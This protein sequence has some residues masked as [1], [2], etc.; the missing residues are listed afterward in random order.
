MSW[1][2]SGFSRGVQIGGDSDTHKFDGRGIQTPIN[3]TAGAME[4]GSARGDSRRSETGDSDTHKFDG[5]SNGAADPLSATR[6]GLRP[7]VSRQPSC[8]RDHFT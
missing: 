5:R 3:S 1:P 6:G 7:S 4:H 8:V 2:D